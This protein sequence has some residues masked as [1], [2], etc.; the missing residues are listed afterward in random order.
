MCFLHWKKNNFYLYLNQ[1]SYYNLPFGFLVILPGTGKLSQSP[2][3]KPLWSKWYIFHNHSHCY[4]EKNQRFFKNSP[5]VKIIIFQ[6]IFSN[7][8]MASCI[9]PGLC[10]ALR[11]ICSS[12]EG[13]LNIPG[14]FIKSKDFQ[15]Q[16]KSILKLQDFPWFSSL[17]W[18][19]S[20][21]QIFLYYYNVFCFCRT[22]VDRCSSVILKAKAASSKILT[23]LQDSFFHSLFS[24][25]TTLLQQRNNH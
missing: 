7:V 15:E 18:T 14:Q 25:L 1:L 4:M 13:L 9:N 12:S 16:K 5:G 20:H 10:H 2:Y 6:G 3:H 23:F 22:D 8:Y 19:I 17:V 24:S 11:V 21:Q